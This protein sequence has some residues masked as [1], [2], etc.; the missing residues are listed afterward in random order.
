MWYGMTI[1]KSTA[2]FWY[3]VLHT[4]SLDVIAPI[5]AT[6][7]IVEQI[8]NQQ[9]FLDLSEY[10]GHRTNHQLRT[11]KTGKYRVRS[12]WSRSYSWILVGILEG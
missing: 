4:E 10:G 2:N 5:L 1:E 8:E 7:K 3:L 6:R 11:V 9:L 12:Y